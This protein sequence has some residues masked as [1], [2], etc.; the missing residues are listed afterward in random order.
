M[1]V[2]ISIPAYNEEKT[3]PGVIK[4]INNTMSKT[5]YNYSI[6]VLDDGSTDNTVIAV[7]K[8]GAIVYLIIIIWV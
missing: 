8:L 7:K 1:K 2:V 5:K 6:L 4:E 3:L